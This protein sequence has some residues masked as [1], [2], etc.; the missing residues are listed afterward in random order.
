MKE[1][2]QTRNSVEAAVD[3]SSLP[4]LLTKTWQEKH[5]KISPSESRPDYFRFNNF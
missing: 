2:G 4:G 5:D 1:M 3:I